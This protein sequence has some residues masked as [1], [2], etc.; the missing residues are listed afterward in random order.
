MKTP[1]LFVFTFALFFYFTGAAFIESFVNYPSWRL[2][3]AG[4]FIAYHRS[5]NVGIVAF[6]V[7]PGLL[8]TICTILMLWWRPA[9]I[10][11][12][13]VWV[14]IALQVIIWVST[15][16]LQ[17]PMQMEFNATG[18][19]EARLS[20][21]IVSNFWLRRIPGLVTAG[22]FVW[23]MRRVI[24]ASSAQRTTGATLA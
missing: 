1:W 9:E 11:R 5:L 20:S 17:I 18:F 3:G 21:L 7:A 13:S 12:W 10:S 19:S 8:A 6:L 15:A 14:A 2:I 23:M 4:E 22:L 16:F 24:A